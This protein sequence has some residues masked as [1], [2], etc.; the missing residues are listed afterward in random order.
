MSKNINE[1]LYPQAPAPTLEDAFLL[2]EDHK[3][4]LIDPKNLKELRL[5]T[6]AD[7]SGCTDWTLIQKKVAHKTFKWTLVSETD[8][9]V[10]ER[11]VET[12]LASRKAKDVDTSH[13]HIIKKRQ[14]SPTPCTEK[15][16]PKAPS[17]GS[18]TASSAAKVNPETLARALEIVNKRKA[19]QADQDLRNQK[20]RKSDEAEEK[21]KREAEEKVKR[22][23][24][25]KVKREAEE[26]VKRE[27]EKKAKREAEEKVKREAEEKAKREAEEKAK[28]EAEEK[29]KREAEE[30]ADEEEGEKDKAEDETTEAEVLALAWQIAQEGELPGPEAVVP[31]IDPAAAHNDD[32]DDA[33]LPVDLE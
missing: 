15:P 16:K 10:P 20:Q 7:K 14:E 22:E 26:K 24:E 5:P 3:I 9:N 8:K 33:S 32:L 23:A 21:A 1:F 18:T 11:D 17:L 12:I 27:A 29:A 30:K 31:G 4:F 6:T 13:L 2:T 28:R 25:E 19:E